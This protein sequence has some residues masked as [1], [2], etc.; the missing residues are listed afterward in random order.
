MDEQFIKPAPTPASDDALRA[1]ATLHYVAMT[2][3]TMNQ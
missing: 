3:W 1:G 2:T